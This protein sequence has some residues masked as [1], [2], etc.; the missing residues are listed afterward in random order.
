MFGGA[1]ASTFRFLG[2]GSME[3][4]VVARSV[5]ISSILS[6]Y[7]IRDEL[8]MASLGAGPFDPGKN[9]TVPSGLYYI[10]AWKEWLNWLWKVFVALNFYILFI[11]FFDIRKIM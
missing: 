3:Q 9:V 6:L 2:A 7:P 10:F 1:A 5:F 11:F 8:T 4:V